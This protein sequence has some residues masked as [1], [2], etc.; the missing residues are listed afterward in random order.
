M[1]PRILSVLWVVTLSLS[2]THRNGRGDSH[3]R[4]ASAEHV[5]D[6]PA[7]ATMEDGSGSDGSTEPSVPPS[8]WTDPQIVAAL[9][10]SCAYHPR[11][12]ADE[13]PERDTLDCGDWIFEQ[14]CVSDVCFETDQMECKGQCVET[15]RTCDGQC[16][17]K[18]ETCK[19]GC[20]TASCKEGCAKQ[21]G[22]CKQG[23][24][25]AVDRCNSGT[26]T[27]VYKSCRKERRARLLKTKCGKL[28][29]RFQECLDSCESSPHGGS[30]NDMCKAKAAPGCSDRELGDC[31]LLSHNPDDE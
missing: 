6:V 28:C 26:C 7:T 31:E 13:M 2:C 29:G 30:C 4:N 23:C 12:S 25:A 5:T 3:S 1:M 21:C 14:S 8:A 27:Q 15:C 10:K 11:R 9:V 20:K 22:A 24:L 18:C 16:T 17:S 19:S